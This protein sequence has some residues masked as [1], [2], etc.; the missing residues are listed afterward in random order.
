MHIRFKPR[1]YITSKG[2]NREP[3]IRMMGLRPREQDAFMRLEFFPW[4]LAHFLSQLY[5][6]YNYP[7][8]KIQVLMTGLDLSVLTVILKVQCTEIDKRKIE[9]KIESYVA[10]KMKVKVIFI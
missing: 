8:I 4:E 1:K 7:N 3:V 6:E 5:D 9:A 2:D 10:D